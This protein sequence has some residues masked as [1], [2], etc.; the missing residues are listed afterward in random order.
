H[1]YDGHLRQEDLQ[2]RKAACDHAFI[3]VE[4]MLSALA[5]KGYPEPEVIAGGSTTFPIHSQRDKV[6][7]SPGTFIF[8]DAGYAEGLSEQSFL[9]AAL[10][11]TRVISLP[12]EN[13]ICL[14]LG[15]KSIA[16]ENPLENRVRFLNAENLVPIS[17]SE[18]HLVLK[19]SD[20]HNCKIGDIFYGVP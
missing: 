6:V 18:E 4:E 13:L 8:W 14:D 12:A 15:H 9:F 17:Q 1:L 7:C 3:K 11:L 20:K 10:V 19:S 5:E 16:S 2:E